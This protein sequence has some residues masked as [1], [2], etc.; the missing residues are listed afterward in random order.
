M[1]KK[2]TDCMIVTG[3]S[4]G[5]GKEMYGYLKTYYKGVAKV[6]GV[7]HN[8]P[9]IYANLNNNIDRDKFLI[10][11]AERFTNIKLFI[12]NA[13]VLNFDL[14]NTEAEGEMLHLNLWQPY[15]MI[16][17]LYSKKLF[18]KGS[19]IIN[20][21][22][23]SGI[24]G[25]PDAPL[26]A[27]TKA[28]IHALTLSWAKKWAIEGITVNSISPGFFNTNLVP[29]DTPKELIEL[30]PVGREAQ[31]SELIPVVEMLLNTPY[32]TGANIVID[33][34]LSL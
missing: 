3:A 14:L 9:D 30:I 7:S 2:L 26:Y 5:L 20:I 6:I 19:Q 34:G 29:G 10:D 25:E 23:V 8:G 32:M 11:I 31:P 17:H 16:E 33:G 27:A 13:G 1:G 21:S 24:K 4:S 22:S 28:G 15:I 12:N 18:N